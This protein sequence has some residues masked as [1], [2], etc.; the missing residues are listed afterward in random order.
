MRTGTKFVSVFKRKLIKTIALLIVFVTTLV[1]SF[2]MILFLDLF[3]YKPLNTKPFSYSL[4]YLN[5]IGHGNGFNR[6]RTLYFQLLLLSDL[7]YL[8]M[9]CLVPV[10]KHNHQNDY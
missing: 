9:S 3:S 2:F 5:K 6:I 10:F 1:F 8:F 4:S 7:I